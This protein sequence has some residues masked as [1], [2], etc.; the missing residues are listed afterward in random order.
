MPTNL[1]REQQQDRRTAIDPGISARRDG[2][3]RADATI[4]PD[5]DW[6]AP[7]LHKELFDSRTAMGQ[8]LV[9]AIGDLTRTEQAPELAL[10][11]LGV[12]AL[13]GLFAD[14]CVGAVEG[15]EKDLWNL[16]RL[17]QQLGS[18]QTSPLNLRSSRDDL[19]RAAIP[20]FTASSVTPEIAIHLDGRF[21]DRKA[22]QRRD[23]LELCLALAEGCR[24]YLVATGQAGRVLW[25]RHRDHL[26]VSVTDPFD[27]RVSPTPGTPR[28]VA[29]RV[30]DARET[31]DPDGT[32]TAV[33]RALRAENSEMLSYDDLSRELRLSEANRRQVGLKLDRDLGL[34]ERVDYPG[35]GRGLSLRK[36][37]LEYL[38][39]LDSEIG[40]QGEL[41][42][43]R[44]PPNPSEYSRVNP[45]AQDGGDG[46]EAD[47]TRDGQAEAEGDAVAGTA[48][49]LPKHVQPVYTE[50]PAVEAAR[51]A[52]HSSEIA[53]VD[54]PIQ[55][56]KGRD[57]DRDDRV[58]GWSYG[59]ARDEL[60]VSAT[61]TNPMQYT[62]CIARALASPWTWNRVLTEDVLEDLFATH[63]RRILSDARN[64]GGLSAER[65]EDPRLFVEFYQEQE[66]RLCELTRELANGD[67]TDESAKRG[68]ITQ[69]AKGL[70]GSIVQLLDLA[71][72][73]LSREVRLPE[74][75]R[76]W[77]DSAR[78]RTLCQTL[79]HSCAIESLYGHHVTYRHLY[80]QREDHRE[81]AM[82]LTVDARDPL[83]ELVGSLVVV[84]PGVSDLEDELRSALRSPGDL[85]DDAPEIGVCIPIRTTASR[86]VVSQAVRR[87]CERKGLEPTREAV[88]LFHAFVATSYDV[89]RAMYYGL[90][91]EDRPREIHVDEI[92][93]ALATLDPARLL[94]TGDVA[95]SMQQA[96]SVLLGA[97]YPLSGAEIARRAGITTQSFRDNREGFVLA[98]LLR[99]A[100]GGWRLS[101]SFNDERY[102]G[103]ILPWFFVDEPD[104]RPLVPSLDL[105]S[106]MDV[107]YE[108]A[109]SLVDDP[110]RFGD[111][112]DVL[113]WGFTLPDRDDPEAIA[114]HRQGAIDALEEEWPWL[115]SVLP[116]IEGACESPEPDPGYDPVLMGQTVSQQPLA[117]A[118]TGR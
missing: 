117:G 82:G 58:M 18:G 52:A 24:V 63:S 14:L 108:L 42:S 88:S 27:P 31:L 100:P 101:L 40:K 62:T 25:E 74:F 75:S 22:D 70:A 41:P 79:A 20:I 114:D 33:L 86:S 45:H 95:P 85:H 37:G 99:E 84:G 113:C 36:A 96:L 16:L 112:D 50:T 47:R 110:A 71:G 11:E 43:V 3:H 9:E 66:E 83:G 59:E 15:R 67:Y 80:E 103:D 64:I 55:M 72:V 7:R 56:L 28:S 97:D 93:R 90:G 21:T 87:L 39:A 10:E 2:V 19:D 6:T 17:C 94:A 1:Q 46:T 78:R 54:A 13:D 105:R 77:S 26:P 12:T 89:A 23:V 118:Q 4:G 106:R 30:E 29:D 115:G 104:G 69:F 111:P 32:A 98:D 102:G 61:Y 60:T 81:A 38:K 107:L 35:D 76:N 51:A 68:E 53:L 109:T 91:G 5:V 8:K 34:A 49:Y 48:E 65:Y 57:G 73:D 44:D 116:V 92:R